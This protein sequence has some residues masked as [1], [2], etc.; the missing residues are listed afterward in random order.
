MFPYEPHTRIAK[1]AAFGH[2]WKPYSHKM[3]TANGRE[4]RAREKVRRNGHSQLFLNTF[5]HDL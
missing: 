2:Q 1:N 4:F 5:T 3:I